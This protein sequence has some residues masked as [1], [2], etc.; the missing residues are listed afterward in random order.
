MPDKRVTVWVQH[1]KD[2][3]S[4]VLQWIDPDTGRRKSKSAGTAEPKEAEKARADLEYELNHGRYQEASRL[5]WER[6]RELFEDEYVAAKRPCTQANYSAMLNA[7]ETICHP[8]RLRS[9]SERTISQFAAGMRE[10]ECRGRK[11][12]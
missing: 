4:L 5:T 7:F 3:V 12:A 9:I 11:G 8:A 1:F 6:F 10:Q 2:R